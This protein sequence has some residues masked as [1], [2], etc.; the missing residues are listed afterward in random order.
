MCLLL[1]LRLNDSR[2]E[3]QFTEDGGVLALI[4]H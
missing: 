2:L 4:Q 1:E 3:I